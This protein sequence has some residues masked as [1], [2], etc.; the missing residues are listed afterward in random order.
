MKKALTIMIVTLLISGCV[1]K[2]AQVQTRYELDG[3]GDIVQR[4]YMVPAQDDNRVL[5]S[6]MII[7]LGLVGLYF[8]GE[9]FDV[10]DEDQSSNR[11]SSNTSQQLPFVLPASSSVSTTNSYI[12]PDFQVV[13]N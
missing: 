13:G 11:N 12:L 8:V 5:E 6:A 4:Q 2:P 7:G 9:L 3:S 1:T 10:W